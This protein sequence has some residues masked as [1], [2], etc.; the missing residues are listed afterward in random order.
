MSLCH[1]SEVLYMWASRFDVHGTV[2][3]NVSFKYIQQDAMLY[4]ILYRCQCC[5]CFRRFLRLSSGAQ[6]CTHSIWYMS[7]L[8]AATASM[9]ELEF[10]LTQLCNIAS[11]WKYLKEVGF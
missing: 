10:Q 6:N 8:L 5:T 9:G 2:H 11:C 7:S 4:N 1:K 3:D